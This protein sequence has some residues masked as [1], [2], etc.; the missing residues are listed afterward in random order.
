VDPS[1]QGL[2]PDPGG[3]ARH[4]RIDLGAGTEDDA[5]GVDDEDAPVGLQ[6]AQDA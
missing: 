1:T 2:Q 4:A 6:C 5:V 3:T